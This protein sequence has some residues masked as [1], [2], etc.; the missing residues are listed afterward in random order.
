MSD[1]HKPNLP[2]L[3]VMSEMEPPLPFSA[4][5]LHCQ[6]LVRTQE[7]MSQQNVQMP[8]CVVPDFALSSTNCKLVAWATW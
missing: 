3:N 1:L 7:S 2:P 4:T 8:R 6:T 5:V